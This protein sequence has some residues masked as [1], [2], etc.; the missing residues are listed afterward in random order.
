M[1]Q[2]RKPKLREA[3]A[4]LWKEVMEQI[5]PMGFGP[6]SWNVPQ[7]PGPLSTLGQW[8]PWPPAA[9]AP[10]R[11]TPE[12]EFVLSGHPGT[13]GWCGTDSR[14]ALS[15]PQGLKVP[16]ACPVAQPYLRQV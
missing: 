3:L 14:H 4:L 11:W 13:A 1:L 15:Q 10:L 7:G 8:Q 9:S 16:W 6:D 12:H 2:I 5:L